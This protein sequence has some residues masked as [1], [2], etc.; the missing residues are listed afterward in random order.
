MSV[1]ATPPGG[2]QVA[3]WRRDG[4]YGTVE[5]V[6]EQL[7]VSASTIY[8]LV[9]AGQFPAIRVG[10]SIRVPVAAVTALHAEV[11]RVGG[12]IDIA[13]WAARWTARNG[14]GDVA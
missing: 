7:R 4:S 8:R 9:N 14:V 10:N 11:T 12:L 6:A 1:Q 5:E 13:D 2:E 3:S